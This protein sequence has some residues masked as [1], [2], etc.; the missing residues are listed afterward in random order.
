MI[1]KNNIQL[2]NF[3][4]MCKVRINM[5]QA[6]RLNW[7]FQTSIRPNY[8]SLRI[9]GRGKSTPDVSWLKIKFSR[10]GTS[11]RASSSFENET[12]MGKMIR[13]WNAFGE[14]VFGSSPVT[15]DD[16]CG[17]AENQNSRR[18][19]FYSHLALN[20]V[21]HEKYTWRRLPF[22]YKPFSAFSTSVSVLFFACA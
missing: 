20:G 17:G 1:K 10:W 11:L 5:S 4:K 15:L 9:P 7:N 18:N 2:G 3:H 13:E 12:K 21:L 19:G 6:Q 16:A 8:L 14:K 22:H